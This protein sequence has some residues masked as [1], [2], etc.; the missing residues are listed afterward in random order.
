MSP[1]LLE[2]PRRYQGEL[3]GHARELAK[4]YEGLGL[5]KQ[6]IRYTSDNHF[7]LR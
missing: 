5:N 1:T 4:G 3:M 7:T 6:S 2:V